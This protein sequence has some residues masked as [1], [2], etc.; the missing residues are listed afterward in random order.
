MLFILKQF[1]MFSQ[2]AVNMNLLKLNTEVV[3]LSISLRSSPRER[4][5]QLALPNQPTSWITC[6]EACSL[7]STDSESRLLPKVSVEPAINPSL[8]RS[9]FK[10]D[11]HLEDTHVHNFCDKYGS[12]QSICRLISFN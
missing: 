12:A 1:P 8:V 4:P 10:Q 11:S 7:T 2:L 5:P 3:W 9:L 6:W